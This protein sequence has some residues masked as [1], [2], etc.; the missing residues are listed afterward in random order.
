MIKDERVQLLFDKAV[1]L[2]QNSNRDEAKQEYLRLLVLDPQH[3]NAHQLLATLLAEEKNYEVSATLF[4]RAIS[5]DRK[6][7]K[8]LNNYGFV[9]AQLNRYDSALSFY[10]QAIHIDSEYLDALNNLANL[11]QTAKNFVHAIALYDR[12]IN[13]SPKYAQAHFNKGLALHSIHKYEEALES[14]DLAIGL[15][16]DYLE[17]YVN[18][19]VTLNALGRGEEAISLYKTLLESN[20]FGA[21][22]DIHNNY[23]NILQNLGQYES[24]LFHF[25]QAVLANPYL[26]IS[27]SNRGNALQRLVRFEEAI[28]SYTVAITINPIVADFFSNRGNAYQYTNDFDSAYKDYLS[29]LTAAPDHAQAYYNL[30]NL[31]KAQDRL[32]DAINC[33]FRA[34][35][36]NANYADAFN[37]LGNIYKD[38]HEN[39]LAI[40]AYD[41]A[42]RCNPKHVDALNNRGVAYQNLLKFEQA[43]ENFDEAIQV[44][45]NSYKAFVNKSIVLLLQG[46]LPK[47]WPFYEA[48]R[49]D[50]EL[51]PNPLISPKPSLELP[52]THKVNHI[53]LLVWAEQGVGDE[54]MFAALF[55]MLSLRVQKL[56][57]LV[58]KRLISLLTRSI[59]N[60]QFIDKSIPIDH[61][62]YD[63]HLPM[64]SVCY[65]LQID[66]SKLSLINSPYLNAD[67]DLVENV[68]SQLLNSKGYRRNQGKSKPILCG[69]SW[70]SNNPKNGA[71]RSIE[72]QRFIEY[73]SNEQVIFVNLQYAINDLQNEKVLQLGEQKLLVNTPVDNFNDLDSLAGLISLCDLVIS[74]D[75]SVVHLSAALGKPTWVLLP[76][77]PDWRWMLDRSDSPWY[78][79]VKLYRQQRSCDWSYPLAQVSD[80]LLNFMALGARVYE[81]TN[82][83]TL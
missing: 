52:L 75:N 13:I 82:R 55:E 81:V 28:R 79:T 38:Q 23:G 50:V 14:Y 24:A 47:A 56:I 3:F 17:A 37:N 33:Y 29:A 53:R 36:I 71:N 32:S 16:I 45:P 42:L 69:V 83:G 20:Q 61:S 19:A 67:R 7:P 78:R 74:V 21:T 73:L 31:L 4:S 62:L 46:A 72:L 2:H 8:V 1:G 11:Y 65:A 41:E 10:E 40:K 76:Y 27:Y 66:E 30:G 48:R 34:I 49:R 64:G 6:N 26:A 77:L 63:F 15:N 80:A 59:S 70:H 39:N 12:A 5:I 54:I 43:I 35:R 58:D 22:A 68:R 60:V 9:L 25:D 44:N 57:V 51:M 18:K